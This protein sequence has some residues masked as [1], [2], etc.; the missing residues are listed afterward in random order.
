MGPRVKRKRVRFAFD[1]PN[2]RA[3]YGYSTVHAPACLWHVAAASPSP[4]SILRH[5]RAG[6]RAVYLAQ[7]IPVAEGGGEP[8]PHTGANTEEAHLTAAEAPAS[9]APRRDSGPPPSFRALAAT[10]AAEAAAVCASVVPTFKSPVSLAPCRELID[11]I[12]GLLPSCHAVSPPSSSSSSGSSEG[13][14]TA[15][16]TLQL[17]VC[18]ADPMTVFLP[19]PLAQRAR[20]TA[21]VSLPPML[22]AVRT[23]RRASASLLV[24]PISYQPLSR[25]EIAALERMVHVRAPVTFRSRSPSPE[26]R[27]GSR[28]AVPDLERSLSPPPPPAPSSGSLVSASPPEPDTATAR[29]SEVKSPPTEGISGTGMAA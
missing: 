14:Q 21:V 6:W 17:E 5:R 8:A 15:E 24:L 4:V 2:K 1:L 13:S 20:R 19:A 18:K 16:F 26:P 27:P 22:V 25:T 10:A 23:Q 3:S 29:A 28:I 12:R 9:I 11:W 7:A